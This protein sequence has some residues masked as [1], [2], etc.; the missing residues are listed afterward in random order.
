[1]ICCLQ[2]INAIKNAITSDTATPMKSL[3]LYIRAN[4]IPNKIAVIT[5]IINII[6]SITALYFI[7]ST[8]LPPSPSSIESMQDGT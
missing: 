5:A 4:I 3:A 2:L 6:R 1:M 7:L 8:A